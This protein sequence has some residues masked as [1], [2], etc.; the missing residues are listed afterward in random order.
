[1]ELPRGGSVINRATPSSFHPSESDAFSGSA[2]S[3]FYILE[4]FGGGVGCT[5]T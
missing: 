4:K 5:E 2:F 3:W 1:M